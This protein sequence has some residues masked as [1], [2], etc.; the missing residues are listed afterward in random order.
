MFKTKL[1]IVVVEDGTEMKLKNHVLKEH[2][3]IPL[4]RDGKRYL[5]RVLQRGTEQYKLIAEYYGCDS[6]FYVD[7]VKQFYVP[8]SRKWIIGW[9]QPLEDVFDNKRFH[10]FDT[11]EEVIEWLKKKGFKILPKIHNPLPRKYR[12]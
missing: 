7:F 3:M 8:A 6:E 9:Y 4:E 10:T 2:R 11:F 5:C 12:R 1:I